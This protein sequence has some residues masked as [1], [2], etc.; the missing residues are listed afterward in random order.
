MLAQVYKTEEGFWKLKEEE[1]KGINPQEKV[2][3]KKEG[4]L[5]LAE[6]EV[7]A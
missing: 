2:K 6:L 4:L 7:R 5:M 1:L 3:Y